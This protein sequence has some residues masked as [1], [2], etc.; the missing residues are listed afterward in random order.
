MWRKGISVAIP[1]VIEAY[2]RLYSA[3]WGAL[4]VLLFC[5]IL[6]FCYLVLFGV[7]GP[8]FLR[9]LFG[10]IFLGLGYWLI[11][12]WDVI[13]STQVLFFW[14]FS[15]LKKIPAAIRN[16]VITQRD[17]RPPRNNIPYG[18]RRFSEKML[19]PSRTFGNIPPE[20]GP[21]AYLGMPP[22]F[23]YF[24]LSCPGILFCPIHLYWCSFLTGPQL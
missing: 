2:V 11:F 3:F 10:V 14:C 9:M 20:I 4:F 6:L 17:M 1:I 7:H 5:V 22:F 24:S 23:Y 13:L 19:F 8:L 12:S 15:R 21:V 18:N 16:W